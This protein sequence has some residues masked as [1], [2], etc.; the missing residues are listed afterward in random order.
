MVTDIRMNE[1]SM[2]FAGGPTASLRVD[3]LAVRHWD[4][5]MALCGQIISDKAMA[6]HMPVPVMLSSYVH[7]KLT[8]ENGFM[9]GMFEGHRLVAVMALRGPVTLREAI[10]EKMI[11]RQDIMFHHAGLGDSLLIC[12]N[13]FLAPD[14]I[15]TDA[16]LRLLQGLT[17][18]PVG[19][20]V[21][22]IF[23]EVST[24]DGAILSQYL[25]AGF[26]I[27]SASAPT[28]EQPCRF[29][30]Q[31]AAIGFDLQREKSGDE[32]DP[33]AD[34]SAIVTLTKLG[35]IGVTDNAAPGKLAFYGSRDDLS[36]ITTV[37]KLP[38]GA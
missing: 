31:R 13:T 9:L 3:L 25:D 8:R 7:D 10:A 1:T 23:A 36:T 30:L 16:M 38:L 11:T 32:V 20:V 2:T 18:T 19:R 27:V 4:E 37:A 5:V 21:D 6:G 28:R 12:E 15:M 14:C 22:H 33:I 26:G 29:V 24:P 35:L 17:M 34:I